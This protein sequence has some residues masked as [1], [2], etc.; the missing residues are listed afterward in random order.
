[1]NLAEAVAEAGKWGN[2]I[3]AL[4][5]I[6]E[7]VDFANTQENLKG[8]RQKA[9]DALQASIDHG[10]ADVAA[11]QKGVETAKSQAAALITAAQTDAA[12]LVADARAV[13]AEVKAEAARIKDIA[14][15]A[16]TAARSEL[17]TVTGTRDSLAAEIGGL[18]SKLDAIKAEA[19]AAF[20]KG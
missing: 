20:G 2:L 6:S 15:S 5:K 3:R 11:A 9:L 4:S 13:A 17:D 7:V 19:A 1:M 18:R 10:K 12:Q 16:A 8:E 14:V